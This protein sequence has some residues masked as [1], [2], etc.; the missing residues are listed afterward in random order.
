MDIF[1]NLKLK[2]YYGDGGNPP[3]TPPPKTHY[4]K[5]RILKPI[6]GDNVFQINSF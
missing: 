4:V 5:T 2:S 1:K 3:V 6:T